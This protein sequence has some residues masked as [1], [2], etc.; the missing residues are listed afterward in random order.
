M[1]V[2]LTFSES[3][4]RS[5][6]RIPIQNDSRVEDPEEFTV[7]LNSTDPD[8][9]PGPPSTITIVDDD[10]EDNHVIVRK[11]CPNLFI[12]F[13]TGVTIGF[14]NETYSSDEGQGS[15]EVCAR[16]I[17][18]GLQRDVEV[19]LVTQDGSAVGKF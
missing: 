12:L 13:S 4:R 9:M 19:A 17:D 1:S 14:E 11:R 5:C 2:D 15:V 18:G 16:V 8:V 3:V 7:T 10:G 6:V